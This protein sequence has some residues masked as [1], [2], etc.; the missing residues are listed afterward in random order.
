MNWSN[1]SRFAG[2]VLGAPL[3]IEALVAFFPEATFIGR[4]IFGWDRLP[5]LAHLALHLDGDP[6]DYSRG[7]KMCDRPACRIGRRPESRK[8]W[9]TKAQFDRSDRRE[10]IIPPA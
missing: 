10:C 4:W 1:Y 3:A 6:E 2:E 9:V 5:K 7:P 8:N